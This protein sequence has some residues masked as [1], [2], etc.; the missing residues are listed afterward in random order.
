MLAILEWG[1]VVEEG[2]MEIPGRVRGLSML[3]LVLKAVTP[4]IP[5]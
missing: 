4:V 2:T 5:G 1:R 3:M